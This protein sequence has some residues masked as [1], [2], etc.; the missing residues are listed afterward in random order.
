MARLLFLIDSGIG[1]DKSPFSDSYVG[2]V[3]L[4]VIAL[5]RDLAARG[6]EVHFTC[7]SNQQPRNV[8]PGVRVHHIPFPD[9]GLPSRLRAILLTKLMLRQLRQMIDRYGIHVVNAHLLYPAGMIAAQAVSQTPARL[10]LTLSSEEDIR[11]HRRVSRTKRWLVEY[12]PL[13]RASQWLAGRALSGAAAVVVIS[14]HLLDV[15]RRE[16]PDSNLYSRTIVPGV[17]VRA[18]VPTSRRVRGTNPA[19][20]LFGAASRLSE[21]KRIDIILRAFSR[22]PRGRA[23]LSVVG[24][25]PQAAALKRLAVE[26]QVSGEVSFRGQVPNT[27]M[28]EFYRSLDAFV[29]ASDSEGLPKVVT[30]ATVSGLAVIASDLPSTQFFRRF[31]NCVLCPNEVGAF[32]EAMQEVLDG[33]VVASLPQD[34][35]SL[36]SETTADAYSSLI[37]D[38][39]SGPHEHR[40]S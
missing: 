2:G 3:E 1:T 13:L 9:V 23:L 10:L 6:H 32:A 16:F 5:C 12:V 29:F 17:D 19:P 7:L 31:S 18:F 33:S 4:D 40:L 28:P 26:L 27:Q 39:L 35:G 8:P 11:A 30:E 14:P 36:A 25:G 34:V 24:D 38:L 22:L 15:V 20:I 21:P 37:V